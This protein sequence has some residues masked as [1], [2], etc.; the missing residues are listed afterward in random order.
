MPPKG[1]VRQQLKRAR[2]ERERPVEIRESLESDDE[3]VVD[4][5]RTFRAGGRAKA[6]TAAAFLTG[7]FV[8]GRISANE[9]EEGASAS[10]SSVGNSGSGCIAPSLAGSSGKNASRNVMRRIDKTSSVPALLSTY[11]PI[12]CNKTNRKINDIFKFLLPHEVFN[13]AVL[14]TNLQDWLSPVSTTIGF[15]V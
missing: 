15:T 8:T 12:W 5:M 1:G 2:D 7:M 14:K 11:I 9:V 13:N 6:A 4:K 3:A 10:S